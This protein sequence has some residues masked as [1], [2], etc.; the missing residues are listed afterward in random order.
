M[1][2]FFDIDGTLWDYRGEIPESTK[3]AIKMLK[4]KGNTPIL[5]TGRGKGHVRDRRLLDMGFSGMIAACGAHVEY[6]D[7]MISEKLLSD[8][9]VRKIIDN[10]GRCRLPFVFEGSVK[11]WI[12]C[13][14]FETDDFVDRM[15]RDMG[16]DLVEI[17]GY[18]PGIEA[19]KFSA[20]VLLS[21]DYDAFHEAMKDDIV[22][23]CHELSKEPQFIQAQ[24]GDN[25][26]RVISLFEG[27]LPGTSKAHGM[28][29]LCDYLNVD[30]NETFAL[31]DS[32][33]DIEMIN[34]AG[35]GIAMGNGS[36][37]IKDAAD[38][39]TDHIH[40]DGLYKALDH[41]GLI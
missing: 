18:V 8:E 20:D 36:Q 5:C 4:E 27:I 15:K 38:Y 37:V 16:D 39:I 3:T 7:K 41:F 23:V 30:I 9:L 28:E 14:G 1:I 29:I 22:F 11:H 26:N 32:I 13:S 31:G 35:T 12:S 25:P 2:V 19:N 33:N 6:E 24:L 40:D 34:A 10:A 21:S 17:E